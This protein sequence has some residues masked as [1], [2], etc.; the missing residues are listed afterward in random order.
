MIG[1]MCFH[2]L[3]VGYWHL[4]DKSVLPIFVRFWR[5]ADIDGV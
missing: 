4:A 3:D 2:R 1:R 5:I